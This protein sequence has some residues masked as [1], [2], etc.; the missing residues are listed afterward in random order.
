MEIMEIIIDALVYPINNIKALVIYV[1][2]GIIAGIAVGGTV[3][4]VATGAAINNSALAGGLGI[5]G[6]LISVIIFLLIAGYE[7]DIV[8]FGIK[9]DPGAPGIDIV[10]Q[11]SNAIKLIIVDIV[12]Y[13]IPVILAAVIGFLIGNG[14]IPSIVII[15]ITIIFSIAAFMARCRLAK[16]DDLGEALAIGEAIGDIS[17]VGILKIILLA[18]LVI[19]IAFILLLII[20][21]ITNWN[22]TIGGILMGIFFVYMAF[23]TNRAIGLLYSD[24]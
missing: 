12:Y 4:G 9:R 5:I 13:I 2:L 11:V 14:L 8:K 22:S 21:A 10:R 17:R 6:V 24:V 20:G 19:I 16:T 7:L 23:F 18:V 3:V 1:V 15:L